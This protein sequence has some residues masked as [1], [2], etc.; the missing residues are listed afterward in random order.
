[1]P[2]SAPRCPEPRDIG[3]TREPPRSAIPPCPQSARGMRWRSFCPILQLGGH[4]F[5]HRLAV[6]RE[7][8]LLAAPPTN[9]GETQKV[10]GL[11]LPFSPFF[12]RSAANRPNSI[13]RVLPGCNFQQILGGAAGR[14]LST[15]RPAAHDG[16]HSQNPEAL[17]DLQTAQ[18]VREIMASE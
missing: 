1:M 12:R 13:R 15:L 11:R 14:N 10:E 6:H 7:V 2:S 18:F 9:V 5:T 16:N 17:P 8:S 3:S 4:A